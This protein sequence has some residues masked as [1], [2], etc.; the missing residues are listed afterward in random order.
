MGFSANGPMRPIKPKVA[1]GRQAQMFLGEFTAQVISQ[2]RD[3]EK[4]LRSFSL[5]DM[6]LHRVGGFHPDVIWSDMLSL[7]REGKCFL[8]CIIPPGS[9]EEMMAVQYFVV[10]VTGTH[11]DRAWNCNVFQRNYCS[12][13]Y[14]F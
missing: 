7:P 1:N 10:D 13:S 11:I 5:I 4:D 12:R 9:C 8:A 14:A 3:T 6:L 2:V